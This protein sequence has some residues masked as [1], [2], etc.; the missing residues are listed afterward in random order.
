MRWSRATRSRKSRC[1]RRSRQMSATVSRGRARTSASQRASTPSTRARIAR[2]SPCSRA[3]SRPSSSLD[4]IERV[5]GVRLPG[6]IFGEVPIT[7][8]TQF[9]S[10]FRAAEQSRVMRIEAA[11]YHA[12]AAAAP[13]VAM[14]VGAKARERI[15]G[16]QGIAA[17]PPKPRATSSATASTP[18]APTCAASSTATRSRSSGSR[19]TRATRPRSGAATCRPRATCPRLRVDGRLLVRPPAARRR[20]GARARRRSPPARSTTSSSSAPD[21][22]DSP[23]RCTERRRACARS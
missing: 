4:G 17:D 16:L 7:L 1:S 6:E 2:C 3:G 5:L 12:L 22:P 10:G 23:P 19:P 20:R 15:G 9:P 8:G 11:L 14:Q 13:D 21:R 18:P